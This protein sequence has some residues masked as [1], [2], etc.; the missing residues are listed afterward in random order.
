[1]Q[2][3]FE[4]KIG[5]HGEIDAGIEGTQL[6][7]DSLEDDEWKM[8]VRQMRPARQADLIDDLDDDIL[9]LDDL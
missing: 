2:S 6:L 8:R 4:R 1:M 3:A 9:N 5:D 7:L